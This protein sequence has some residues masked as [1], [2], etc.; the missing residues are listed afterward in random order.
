MKEQQQ[1]EEDEI[2]VMDVV[3]F[4]REH[5]KRILVFSAAGLI[6]AVAAFT[7]MRV[8]E[9][10][11]VLTNDAGIDFVLLKKMQTNLPRIAQ[12]M[13]ER[14]NDALIQELSSES[15]W[16][17]NFKPT[18]AFT[19]ADLK[20]LGD[21]KVDSSRIL[22]LIFTTTE[23]SEERAI[24]KAEKIASFFK[25][26]SALVAANDLLQRYTNEV[27]L[28]TTQVEK[29]KFEINSE[30]EYLKKRATNLEQMKGKYPQGQISI[31]SQVLDPKDSGSKYLPISTQLIAVYS[32]IS[33]QQEALERNRDGEI[34]LS[35]KREVL[36]SL[37]KNINNRFDGLA[38]LDQTAKDMGLAIK[39]NSEKDATN[40]KKMLALQKV[41]AEVVTLDN[42]YKD[43][44]GQRTPIQIAKKGEGLF[45]LMGALGGLFLG[46]FYALF[47]NLRSRYKF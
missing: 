21:V 18:Y 37:E 3:N 9:A 41:Y 31:N 34:L 39:N 26:S 16:L 43:G 7:Q 44:L 4:F 23:K 22:N 5:S 25:N 17:K 42:Q 45:I 28:M 46:L 27:R 24:E 13:G 20:D 36:D 12:Q 32:D 33:M 40:S 35:V 6:L 8:Y 14:N 11:A 1:E 2:T 29:N 19:K 30:I 47:V 10:S 15:W 38:I